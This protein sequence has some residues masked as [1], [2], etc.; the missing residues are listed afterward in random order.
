M[1]RAALVATLLAVAVAAVAPPRVVLA[2]D[3][4]ERSKQLYKRG[5]NAFAMGDY[6]HA[7]GYFEEAYELSQRPQLLWNVA[8]AHRAWFDL[9]HDVAHLR[10]A[11]TIYQ[12][13]ASLIGDAGER[14]E[15]QREIARLDEQMASLE[16]R[17]AAPPAAPPPAPAPAP[18]LAPAPAPTAPPAIAPDPGTPMA[19]A[20]PRSAPSLAVTPPAPTA[21]EAPATPVWK[22]WWPWTVMGALVAGGAAVGLY[23]GL[24]PGTSEPDGLNAGVITPTFH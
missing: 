3:A 15:A 18:P 4:K 19:P 21:S 11:R 23:Y 17:P 10:R 8:A 7:A 5:E 24:R 22:R 6:A 13:Y 12:N 20:E 14:D 9:D 2:G 1:R 16:R